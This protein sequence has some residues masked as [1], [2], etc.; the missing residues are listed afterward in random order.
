MARIKGKF[1]PLMDE[2]GEDERWLLECNDEQKFLYVLILFT[3]YTTNGTAPDN[4]RYYVTRYSLHR[5]I[6]RVT[7]DLDHIKSLFPK[8]ISKDKKLSLLNSVTY[9]NRV[10]AKVSLEGDK[11]VEEELEGEGEKAPDP[12]NPK[13]LLAHDL[14]KGITEIQ[15]T[16][17][18]RTYPRDLLMTSLSKYISS[19]AQRNIFRMNP[20]TVY[21]WLEKDFRDRRKGLAWKNPRADQEKK[22]NKKMADE[23]ENHQPISDEERRALI[24]A[25]LPK[26]NK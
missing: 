24:S 14:F 15:K 8:L 3:I 25:A 5:R 11:E 21:E 2:L 16:D 20:G 10:D 17:L 22:D 1:A 18:V 19:A 13:D 26:V 4:A 12:L 6:D 23:K 7:K 9:E